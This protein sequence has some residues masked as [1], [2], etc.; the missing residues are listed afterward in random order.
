MAKPGKT[1]S[2][3]WH[4]IA[5]LRV[6]LR[7]TVKV[8]KQFFRG[9]KW[10][11][12]HDPFNNQFFR[13][14]PEAYE[15]ISRLRPD[16]TVEEVWEECLNNNP[17]NAPGQEDAQ[18]LLTQLYFSN[19]LFSE[20]PADSTKLFER[21]KE[22][23]QRE[24]SGWFMNIMFLRIPLIDPEN[25]L[26]RF[27]PLIKIIIGPL[28]GMLWLLVVGTALKLVFDRF[29]MV[30]QMAQGILAPDNLF[31]LYVGLV[32]VKSLH[33]FGHAMVC[34]RY[35]G[36]VHTM[37]VMFL[38]FT[39]LPYMDATASW[40]F[41][42][43]LQRIFVG[44]AGMITE[45]LIAGV[46]VFVWAYTGQ[47]T[48]HSLAYNIMFIASVSTILFNGNFLLHFDGYFILADILDIPNLSQR[49][50]GQLRHI[51][52]RYLFGYKD[53]MSQAHSTKE[54][55]WLCVYGI[56]SGI[57]HV[58]VFT[59]I[60]MFV[61]DKFLLLGMI[62]ALVC[63]IAWGIVPLYQLIEY[64]SSSPRLFKTRTRAIA[65][66][67]GFA[68]LII[69]ILGIIPFP[70][71]FR[72]P[73]V[74]E[75]LQY[76]RVISDAPGFVTEVFVPTGTQVEEGTPLIKLV[77]HELDLEIKST[78][79]QQEET[80]AL[81]M[82]SMSKEVADLKA[83]QKRLDTIQTKLKDLEEQKGDLIVKAR[84]S[85]TWVSPAATEMMGSWVPKGT[86]L[87]EIVEN[88]E[89]HF[90][91]VVSQDDAANLFVDKITKA[92]IR[93]FGHEGTN[94]DVVEYKIIPYQ[95]EKLPSAAL[96]WLGGGDLAVSPRDSS[97]L[98]A[99]EPFFLILAH[100]KSH[101]NVSFFQGRA[102][103]LRFSMHPEP[104]LVQWTKSL[105]QLLQKR[106]QI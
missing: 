55:F 38:V 16:R 94:L 83:V 77:N 41:R 58:F 61:A 75:A 29:D 71:R 47:G 92:E 22:R 7:P 84:I 67:A 70:N 44:A 8:R 19:L 65:I 35:G 74:L 42:S 36:E 25:F 40:A 34:K 82:M 26:K 6:S 54:A 87:G 27:L 99:S 21:Y 62:I 81:Q 50:F 89:F 79:A 95:H 37:G 80:L 93:I 2:E 52:E 3:S 63:I 51:V 72:A 32:I 18:Q 104:L 103:K 69:L 46:A 31:L 39:P 49:S 48:L 91:T 12:L 53:S 5:D 10:Y 98:Q 24:I 68:I 105:R 90:S 100:V 4:R 66:C 64:L 59:H 15:F 78:K 33:E 96:G 97:G 86:A 57:F 23:R 43:R 28:G 85:G 60:I 14:R 76:I 9:E 13:L 45:I 102:G 30:T 1:F 20:M 101:P 106:Y 88:D 56:A 11:I 17:E 73:G